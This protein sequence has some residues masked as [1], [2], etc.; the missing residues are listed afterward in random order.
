MPL[1]AVEVII[2]SDNLHYCNQP[3]PWTLLLQGMLGETADTGKVTSS[4]G[5]VEVSA[6]VTDGSTSRQAVGSNGN[7]MVID[8]AGTKRFIFDA[9]GSGHADVEWTTYDAH[10]DLGLIR[11]IEDDRQRD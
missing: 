9:E 6:Y 11:T 2:L 3:V 8:N 4:R 7:L 1:C 10:D 5:V